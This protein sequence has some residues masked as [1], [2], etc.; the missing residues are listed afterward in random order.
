MSSGQRL[1]SL[2]G[3]TQGYGNI[4]ICRRGKISSNRQ[5]SV[6]L[7][8]AAGPFHNIRDTGPADLDRLFSAHEIQIWARADLPGHAVVA[9]AGQPTARFAECAARS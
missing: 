7:V 8:V 2:R 9:I 5:V 6:F 3:R 1:Q 4:L